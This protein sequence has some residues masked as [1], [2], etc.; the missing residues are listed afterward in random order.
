MRISHNT[1]SWLIC[2]LLVTTTSFAQAPD[3]KSEQAA[4][5]AHIEEVIVIGVQSVERAIEDLKQSYVGTTDS[6]NFEALQLFPADSIGG[7][8]DRIAGA[9]AI[10]DPTSSQP[11]FISLRG[12]GPQYNSI[13]FD[14]IDILNSS[15]NTR[16]TRLDLFPSSLVHE[17][18]VFKVVTADMDGNSIGGHASV[19][20][21]RAFDGGPQPFVNVKVQHGIYE[22]DD[23][24]DSQDDS[25][26]YDGVGKFTFGDESQFGIVM[27]FDLQ[28]HEYGQHSQRFNEGYRLVEGVDQ[29]ERDSAFNAIT[30]QTDIERQNAFAK[31][32]VQS[33]DRLYGFAALH[34]FD[35]DEVESRNRT[36]HF[37]DPIEAVDVAPGSVTYRDSQGIVS[38]VDRERN[39]ETLLGSLGFDFLVDDDTSL[40]VRA[41]Y[42][43]VDLDSSFEQSRSF[44]SREGRNTARDDITVNFDID[45]IDV[46]LPDPTV[47]TDPTLFVQE[48]DS[49]GTFNQ[50]DVLDDKLSSFRID[51]SDNFYPQSTGWGFKTGL[52][53]RRID[54]E[55]D[56]TVFRYRASAADQAS[57]TLAVNNPL[58]GGTV[59][60]LEPIYIDRDAYWDFVIANNVNAGDGNTGDDFQPI[61]FNKEADYTLVEDVYSAYGSLTYGGDDF[62][63]VLGLR[64]E[65]TDIKNLGFLV[66][67]DPLNLVT[68]VEADDNR[69]DYLDWLPS[70]HFVY[71]P[72]T[73][74][75]LR[76]SYA[77]TLGRGDFQDF[78]RRGSTEAVTE[79]NGDIL[80]R[81]VGDPDLEAR[82]ADNLDF[83][84]EYYFQE[85]GGFASASVFYKRISNEHYRAVVP[86]FNVAANRAQEVAFVRDDSEAKVTGIEINFVM[87]SF[88]FAPW[89]WNLFGVHANYTYT[90]GEWLIPEAVG[91]DAT[92]NNPVFDGTL[93]T[94]DGLRSQPDQLARLSLRYRWRD[95]G[96]TVTGAYR[97]EYFR[98]EGATP[99]EDVYVDDLTRVTFASFYRVT[100]ELSVHFDVRN[101]NKPAWTEISGANRD[102][103]LRTIEPEP[104]YWFG[105][106]YRM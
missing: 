80:E 51:Y 92:G 64:G 16:G 59:S 23:E 24:P 103:V 6:L 9:V 8:F 10:V 79:D 4:D 91:V 11:R 62:R 32:E 101:L 30:F 83:G 34:Y 5:P 104:S 65:Y 17:I 68:T 22:F 86:T 71:S 54:R 87:N 61:I 26:R 58:L 52:G 77:K 98:S 28:R 29:P 99:A 36:G 85:T 47:F 13:D 48:G 76:T 57:Y 37:V 40:S 100:D 60:T 67:E 97:G 27:G 21:I 55:F 33:S 38:F 25:Y 19:R 75:T 50:F 1:C 89:P 3:N 73:N 44:V 15:S 94:I 53:A 14:G 72:A 90:D 49:G 78:A 106:K 31:F 20:T 84:I 63:F 102:L 93:R 39:R 41:S 69:Y 96:I 2:G 46:I 12:F 88:E 105:L 66:E 81:V 35:M 70:L 42:S 18:N 45:S 56:R 95:L 82:E 7:Q 43:R 74:I